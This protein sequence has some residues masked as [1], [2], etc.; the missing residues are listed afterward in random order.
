[1]TSKQSDGGAANGERVRGGFQKILDTHGYGFQ[2]AVQEQLTALVAEG[3]T[4]WQFEASSSSRSRSTRA[5]TRSW[6]VGW[7]TTP[8]TID[9][10]LSVAER[11]DVQVAIHTDT[12]NEAGFVEDTIK[13]FKGR[14]IHS[15]HTEGAG[16]AHAPD[17]IK[18]CGEPYVLPS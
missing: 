15:F 2:Y 13:A 17:N 12:I 5:R 6:P 3:P 14:T 1:M 10:C 9:T 18:V 7:G 11:Y 16:G 4:S 8:A